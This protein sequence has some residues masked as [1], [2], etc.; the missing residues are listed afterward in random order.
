MQAKRQQETTCLVE[1]KTAPPC[2][3]WAFVLV[4]VS[5][6]VPWPVACK[7]FLAVAF[8]HS[9]F[10][11]HL[12]KQPRGKTVDTEVEIAERQHHG[13]TAALALL[14]KV[15]GEWPSCLHFPMPQEH[16]YQRPTP[17]LGPFSQNT[18]KLNGHF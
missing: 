10:D 11:M 7:C 6:A 13:E 5:W 15:V 9:P 1:R 16:T 3:P 4:F 8:Q 17:S 14:S 18:E 2:S 12:Q